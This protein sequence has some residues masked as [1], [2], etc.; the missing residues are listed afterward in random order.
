MK[1]GGNQGGRPH[2]TDRSTIT[3]TSIRLQ[4][5]VL[6][7]LN[8][9]KQKYGFPDHNS[10]IKYYLPASIDDNKPVFLTA[11]QAYYLTHRQPIYR[12]IKE[13]AAGLTKKKT[14]NYHVKGYSA[15]PGRRRQGQHHKR[16]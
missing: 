7:L 13:A 16:W 1:H 3:I 11:K 15:K 10:T 14:D 12:M 9:L 5:S 4:P 2:K 8:Q 6:Q